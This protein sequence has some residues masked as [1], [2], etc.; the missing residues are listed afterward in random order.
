MHASYDVERQWT[1]VE[2]KRR[3]VRIDSQW[4]LEEGLA[5]SSHVNVL[6]HQRRESEPQMHRLP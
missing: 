3:A 4:H 1:R 2:K 6:D 5:P